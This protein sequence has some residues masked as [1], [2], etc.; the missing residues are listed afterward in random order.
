M[1]SP[2]SRRIR[3]IQAN[4]QGLFLGSWS[5]TVEGNQ[6]DRNLY[7]SPEGQGQWQWKN[8][9]YSS[10][11]A[12]RQVSGHD[13]QSLAGLNPLYRDPAKG[14]LHVSGDSPAVDRGE[15]VQGSGGVDID[16]E[17]RVMRLIDIG[18]DETP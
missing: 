9:T 12:Y 5:P 16:G 18:A 10:F 8:K 13:G 4:E 3:S 11:D 2:G 15:L 17:P 7:F 6:I 1:R 14:D